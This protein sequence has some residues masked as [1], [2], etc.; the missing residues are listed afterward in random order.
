VDQGLGKNIQLIDIPDL[1]YVAS[2]T[3]FTLTKAP[4]PNA[5]SVLATWVLSREGQMSSVKNAEL[6]TRRTDI[7]STPT[8]DTPKPGQSYINTA[9][10]DG[11][12]RSRRIQDLL[13]QITT[14]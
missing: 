8:E 11:T 10:E 5:A 9:S 1:S 3:L 12:A 14:R 4:H 2:D 13:T 6:P 7:P